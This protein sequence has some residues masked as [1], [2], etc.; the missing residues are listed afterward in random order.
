MKKLVLISLLFSTVVA[1]ARDIP[2]VPDLAFKEQRK[3]ALRECKVPPQI[4]ILPP[5]IDKDYKACV[6][7]YYLPNSEMAEGNLKQLGL[8]KKEDKLIS[9]EIA[10]GFVRAY[11]FKYETEEKSSFFSKISKKITKIILCDDSMHNCYR[12][13]SSVRIK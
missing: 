7:A 13:E 8:I 12:V 9:V 3:Q 2:P 11:E 10:E 5:Q 6:N 4:A 1:V